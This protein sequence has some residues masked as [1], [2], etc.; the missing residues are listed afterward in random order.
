[1]S[2]FQRRQFPRVPGQGRAVVTVD[3]VTAEYA[4]D[5][6]CA[7]GALL[8]N[9]PTLAIGSRI[10]IV[11]R[12][13]SQPAIRVTGQVVRQT[14]ERCWGV[15]FEHDGS[16]AEDRIQAF[17]L[18]ALERAHRLRQRA[19]VLVL[20]DSPEEFAALEQELRSLGHHAIHIRAPLDALRH[21]ECEDRRVDTV[22]VDLHFKGGDGLEVLA[23]L[24]EVLPAIRR[25]A[26]SGSVRPAQLKLAR[27]SG[28]VH[29]VLAKPCTAAALAELIGDDGEPRRETA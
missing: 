5:N 20:D 25:V 10:D 6:L 2:N 19:V 1:L 8:S 12:L 16:D 28:L 22:M 15:A 7:G 9:G 23:Y 24:S 21:L 17:V 27:V 26:M 29:A 3:H 18:D 4:L 14:S 13:P 11:L